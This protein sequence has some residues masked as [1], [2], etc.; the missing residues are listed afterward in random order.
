[1]RN[2]P[3]EVICQHCLDGSIMPIKMRITDESGERQQ[4]SVKAFRELATGEGSTEN[5]KIPATATLRR[6][7]CKISVFESPK[8]VTLYYNAN[9]GKWSAWT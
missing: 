5:G 4:Y 3:A 2:E 1:M 6:F 9:S 7:D 8:D